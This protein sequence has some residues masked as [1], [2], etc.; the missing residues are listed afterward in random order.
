MKFRI[1][2]TAALLTA[3]SVLTPSFVSSQ[4]SEDG[5]YQPGF[6]QPA[7]DVNVNRPIDITLLNNTG[8]PL[9]YDTAEGPIRV[10]GVGERITLGSFFIDPNAE[11]DISRTLNVLINAPVEL[12]EVE[13]HFEIDSFRNNV[14]VAIRSARTGERIDRGFYLDEKGRIYLF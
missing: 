2:A 3:L 11:N 10:L 12:S 14:T 13:L 6:W 5:G 8:I 7:E 9:E 4:P 1:I